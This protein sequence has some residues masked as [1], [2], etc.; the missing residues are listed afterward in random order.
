MVTLHNV[1][2]ELLAKHLYE[3][4]VS[5]GRTWEEFLNYQEY[6]ERPDDLR[7]HIQVNKMIVTFR[8][9]GQRLFNSLTGVPNDD[10]PQ[11]NP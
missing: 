11:C 9:R 2:P 8:E 10:H 3:S 6:M 7:K 5:Y 4:T 1:T